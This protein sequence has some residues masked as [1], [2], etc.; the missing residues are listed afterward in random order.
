L[1]NNF[2][3]LAEIFLQEPGLDKIRKVIEQSD[4]VLDFFKIFPELAKTV[5]PVKLE[6]KILVLKIENAALR[7]ELKHQ[8]SL[9]IEK[10]NKYFNNSRLVKSVRFTG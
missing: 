2:K 10:I 4:V 9:I 8:E 7:S 5:E 3:S 6:K 1:K